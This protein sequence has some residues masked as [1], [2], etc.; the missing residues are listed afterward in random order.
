MDI[1]DLQDGLVRGDGARLVER[2]GPFE[3]V[4]QPE[5]PIG[6]KRLRVCDWLSVAE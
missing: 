4:E 2:L 1:R 5:A 3:G 6:E